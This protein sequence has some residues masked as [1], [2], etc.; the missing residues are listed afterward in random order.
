MA[1]DGRTGEFDNGRD[2][3]QQ[4]QHKLF[5]LVFDNARST[6]DTDDGDLLYITPPHRSYIYVPLF[7]SIVLFKTFCDFGNGQKSS[8]VDHHFM[9]TILKSLQYF[10]LKRKG[11]LYNF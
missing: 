4:Q 3:D 11:G 5:V 9:G 2:V 6:A 7:S 1:G 10:Y 8:N